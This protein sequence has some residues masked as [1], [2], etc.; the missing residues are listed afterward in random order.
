[1]KS[2]DL[3][4]RNCILDL[5]D[6]MFGETNDI[7]WYYDLDS[8]LFRISEKLKKV[9]ELDSDLCFDSID[10][11]FSIIVKRDQNS[12]TTALHSV[13]SGTTNSICLGI[14]IICGNS[15]TKSFLLNGKCRSSEHDGD[16]R[17]MIIAGTFTDIEE[18]KKS[19]IMLSQAAYYD[20]LTGLMNRYMFNYKTS[21]FINQVMSGSGSLSVLYINIDNFKQINDLYGHMAGDETIREVSRKIS[22]ILDKEDILSRPCGDEFLILL[23]ETSLENLIKK[24]RKVQK[25]INKQISIDGSEILLTSSIGVARFPEDGDSAEELLK[26]AN[27]AMHKAKQEGKRKHC[28][29]DKAINAEIKRRIEM[30]SN[31]RA[32][33][34]KG[35]LYIE[36][37]PQVDSITG[38]IAGAEALLRWKSP[39]HGQ[40]PPIVFIPIAEETGLIIP[41]GI[42]VLEQAC[43][44]CKRWIDSYGVLFTISVNIS[45]LQL[46]SEDFLDSVMNAVG[47]SGLPEELLQLE[48]TESTLLD[49]FERTAQIL[50]RLRKRGITIALDDFGTGFSSL[51]YLKNLPLDTL[52]IDKSFIDGLSDAGREKAIIGTIISLAHIL[53]LNV[54]AEGVET[55][56]QAT[57]L[58]LLN[59]NLLQ[60]YYFSKPKRPEYLEALFKKESVLN[61]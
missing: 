42:W 2:T 10:Q 59:C 46:K 54:I 1:M 22:T 17:R 9:C 47:K 53:N 18:S 52:K 61:G 40:V 58:E 24:I 45:T 6:G 60:G 48:I 13:Y 7:L 16:S 44:Q 8:G 26:N 30:E 57:S 15:K 43:L 12:L 51:N 5:F 28:F 20:S 49:N 35:E 50:E 39:V 25:A 27:T 31:L 19:D 56:Q 41:I 36:Y 14:R 29:Y 38:V 23:H 3:T 33:L 55:L 32:A 37:Q 11:L 21:S 4:K 34:Q